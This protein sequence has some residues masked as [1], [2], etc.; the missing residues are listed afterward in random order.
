MGSKRK[1]TEKQKDFVKKKLKVGKTAAKPD[2]HTDTS[3]S[4]RTISLPH[5]GSLT[6]NAAAVGVGVRSEAELLR[7]LSLAKHHAAATRREVLLYVEQHLPTDNPSLFKQIITAVTPLVADPSQSVR[8]QL[9]LLLAACAHAAPGLLEL[10]MRSLVLFVHAAMTHIQP[11]IRNWSSKFLGILVAHAGEALARMH[12]I[13]TLRLFFT[14]LA[15]PLVDDKRLVSLAV[16]SSAA[17]GPLKS[18]RIGHLSVLRQFLAAAL[19]EP[20]AEALEDVATIHPLT[21]RYLLPS[22]SRP[23]VSLK[24][25]VKEMPAV[26]AQTSRDDVDEGTFSLEDL[27]TLLTEDLDTRRKVVVDVFLRPMVKNLDNLM[28]EGG[29]VGREAKGV[30]ELIRGVLPSANALPA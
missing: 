26:A 17:A 2:N 22:R 24:L 5:Q 9:A 10:H 1:K 14:V 27:A 15:W 3:F 21:Q 7:H 20:P 19:S 18:A 13:K 28:K 23:F 25:F 12:F 8:A 4:A 16:T 6:R 11:E 30:M 29:E